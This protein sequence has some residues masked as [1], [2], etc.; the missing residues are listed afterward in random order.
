M[1]EP[2]QEAADQEIGEIVRQMVVQQ[3]GVDADAATIAAVESVD[4]PDACLG[5]SQPDVMCAQV[6][7]P[8]Y[9]VVIEVNGDQY[10]YHT[11][12]TGQQIVLAS[13]PEAQVGDLVLGWQQT[14][15]TCKE[16]RI[17]SEGLAFGPCLGRMMAGRLVV[18]EREQELQMF[19][20]RY[21]PF[22]ADTPAG[23]VTFAGQGTAEASEAEQRMI[24]E[25][26]RQAQLEAESGRSGA[27]WGLGIAWHREGGIAGFCD[28]LT[29]YVTGQ[30]YAASCRTEPAATVAQRFLTEAELLQLYRWVDTFAAFEEVQS[31][32][33]VPDAMTTRLV[34]SG[35]GEEVA[36]AGTKQAIADFAATLYAGLTS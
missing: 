13:A 18:P 23:A 15:D 34:F 25:W 30:V 36:G 16:L 10:E 7:T 1:A 29:A 26:A 4:W 17:G 20:E 32:G 19:L 27:S 35:G 31:D 28:D 14:S 24:A 22:E 9:R 11:D 6:I 21:A 3:L 5:V 12:A 2:G 8:G 33:N